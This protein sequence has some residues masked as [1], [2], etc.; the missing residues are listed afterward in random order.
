MLIQNNT[1]VSKISTKSKN[2]AIKSVAVLGSGVMGSQIAMHFANIGITVHLLDIAPKDLLPEETTAGLALEN[3]KVRNRVVNAALASALKLSPN[4]LYHPDYAKKIKTGNFTDNL[5]DIAKVDWVIEVVIENLAIKQSLYTEVEKY[6]KAGTLITSNTSG[7]PIHL[8]AEGRSED[9]RKNFCGTHFFN[10]PRYLRLLEII[11]TVDTDSSVLDFLMH[12][13]DLYLGKT[14]VLC[15]DTPAF[16]ANRLG[17][18]SILETLR[19]MQAM[20][21]SIDEI[22]KLTGTIIGHPKSATFRTA[23]VV[24]LDTLINVTN[25][26]ATALDQDERKSLFILPDYLV[27]MKE[28]KWL[29]EKTKQGFYKKTTTE[30]G[31]KLILSLNLASLEYDS[32]KPRKFASVEAAKQTDDLATRI[33]QLVA[34][35][36][37]AATFYRKF[38]AGI[39]SYAANRIPEI[40]DDLYKLDLA[41]KTGFGWELGIFE[42]WD[43]IGIAKGIELI[44]AENLEVAEWVLKAQ[45]AQITSFYKSSAGKRSYYNQSTQGYQAIPGFDNFILLPDLAESKIWSNAGASIYDLGDGIIN[46]EFHSKMNTIGSE[47]VEGITKAIDLAEQSF[48]GLTISNE[49]ANFSIGANLGIV[50]MYALDQEWDELDLMI[51]Q[52]QNTMVRARYSSIPVVVAPHNMTLGGGCELTLHA[53]HVQMHAETYIGLVEFGVGVIPGGGGSKE[54]ARRASLATNNQGDVELNVLQKLY[55]NIATAKVATSAAEARDMMILRAQDGITLNRDRLLADAKAAALS[56]AHA[57][58]TQPERSPIKVQGKTGLAGLY[59]GANQMLMGKY[60]SEHDLKIAQKLAYVM[61][62]G[63]LS[64]PQFVSEQYLLDLERQAFLSLCGERKTQERMQGI[65]NGNKVVRN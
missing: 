42:T 14:T 11:P 12:Y 35:N 62:G 38:F 54:M 56:F 1:F 57:G 51:R 43:A 28:N 7:I 21:F 55:M 17:V 48:A 61:C 27:K 32:T 40:S 4:P 41:I 50:L 33:K 65:L 10:P 34:G 19:L 60:I 30:T 13:G 3:P 46:L 23:D 25:N 22:D 36:D 52:F 47:V 49:G 15:K 26:L 39:F 31:E 16:I 59:V 45:E 5:A 37:E 29:G 6:R 63:D 18:F 8:L 53:D 9:F 20:N 2:R 64:T 58:Y 24:G 44:K